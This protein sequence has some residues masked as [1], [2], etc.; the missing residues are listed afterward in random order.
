M[1]WKQVLKREIVRLEKGP[2]SP[3]TRMKLARLRRKMVQ[4]PKGVNQQSKKTKCP[5]GHPYNRENT[6]KQKNGARVCR[7]CKKLRRQKD[8]NRARRT[9]KVSTQVA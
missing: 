9:T 2:N 7:I 1:H 5:Q 4:N 8:K 6:I 3:S